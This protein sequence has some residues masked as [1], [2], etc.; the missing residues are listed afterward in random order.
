M[1]TRDEIL[2][3]KANECLINLIAAVD[4]EQCEALA[5]LLANLHNSGEIDILSACNSGQLDTIPDTLFFTFQ[6]VFC[7]TLPRIDCHAEDAMTASTHV[8]TKADADGS[9]SSVSEALREWFQQ[10][11]VRTEEGLAAIHR[12]MD[13]QTGTITPLLLAGAKQDPKRFVLVAL[14]LTKH[15]QTQ[16]RSDALKVL[17]RLVPQDNDRLL[18]RALSRF[19]EVVDA[20]YSDQDTAIAVE[21]VLHLLYRNNGSIVNSVRPLLEKA[22]EAPSPP[23]RLALVR[24]LQNYR[25]AF[26]ESMIDT[27]LSTLQ[28]TEKEDFNTIR[29]I[30]SLLYMWDIDGDRHPRFSIS[31]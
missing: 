17:G 28:T 10:S 12:N 2:V 29:T 7:L 4:Y 15:V 20:S 25:D 19:S 8:Y 27:I 9:A 11:S 6:S 23:L 31:F 16:I 18:H 13:Y 14:D 24:S 1:I 30:N 3:A 22:C 5:D 21:A 26:D